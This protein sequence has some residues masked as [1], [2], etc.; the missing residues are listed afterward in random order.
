MAYV[1]NKNYQNVPI[2]EKKEKKEKKEKPYNIAMSVLA[3]DKED[4]TKVSTYKT[5]FLVIIYAMLFVMASALNDFM[6]TL[7]KHYYKGKN[8]VIRQFIYV[9]VIL[10]LVVISVLIYSKEPH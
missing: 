7:F 6:V 9:L 3:T 8:P 2:E 10:A 1:N 5:V 4:D